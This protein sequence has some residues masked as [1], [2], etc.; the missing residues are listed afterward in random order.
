MICNCKS[1]SVHTQLDSIGLNYI[2][3]DE[4]KLNILSRINTVKFIRKWPMSEVCEAGSSF[5]QKVVQT[6]V[7][8]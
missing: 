7:S 4:G 3:A 8:A 1:Y 6:L 2:D 5:P